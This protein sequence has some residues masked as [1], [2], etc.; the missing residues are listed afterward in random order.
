MNCTR[1]EL[2]RKPLFLLINFNLSILKS[3]T[4]GLMYRFVPTRLFCCSSKRPSDSEW[5][6]ANPKS[7]MTQLPS[8]RTRMFFDLMSRW[9]IAG[10]PWNVKRNKKL[11]HFPDPENTHV[12]RESVTVWEISYFTGKTGQRI[13]FETF[14]YRCFIYKTQLLT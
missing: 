11:K 12:I 7:A 14:P 13:N 5:V 1:T 2:I 8:S 6:T 4:S 3:R 10:L 9:A